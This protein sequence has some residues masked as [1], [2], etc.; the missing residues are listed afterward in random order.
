MKIIIFLST[1]IALFAC[2]PQPQ[3][4]QEA[5]P[6]QEGYE[7]K[8]HVAKMAGKD[9][10]LAFYQNDDNRVGVCDTV[11]LDS[12]GY[13]VF[14]RPDRRLGRGL[15]LI[16]FPSGN[17]IQLLI[18]SQQY[19]T[20]TSDTTD[21]INTLV[22]ENSPENTEFIEYQKFLQT[23]EKKMQEIEE[24]FSKETEPDEAVREKY[25]KR[26]DAIDE[27]VRARVAGIRKQYPGTVL[28]NFLNF[29]LSPKIPDYS[30][31]V[32][33]DAP[34]REN[35]IRRLSLYYLKKHYWDY[36]DLTDTMFFRIKEFKPKLDRYFTTL[37]IPNPDTLYEACVS[38]IEKARPNKTMFRYLTE[39][40]IMHAFNHEIMGMD[41]AFVR[42]GERYY[43]SGEA[44]WRTA[45]SQKQLTD[46]IYK[47]QYNL[48]GN[49]ALDLKLPSLEGGVVSLLETQ[50]PYTLLLF[51]EPNCGHCKTVVPDVK[52]EIF[53][54]FGPHGLKVFAVM[55]LTEKKEWEAFVE[56]N[57][58]FDFINCYDPN[59][60]SNYWTIYNVFSTPVLYLLDK[61]KKIIAKQLSVEQLVGLLREEYKRKGI[62][63]R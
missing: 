19:F 63:V 31:T 23:Q 4:Q 32:A 43:L 55:T 7:I 27:E 35:E 40:C 61:D 18:G 46:E 12:A 41:K 38:I 5:V 26:Q 22:F 58:L 29:T 34:D 39:Y 53:D 13:G 54:R 2:K 9:A 49:T 33:A 3:Q 60:Q 56:K 59:R 15:Y 62:E 28:A 47:R 16:Y 48:L 45:E 24:E 37:I 50:A 25:A 1:C 51:W 17:M 10:M 36:T 21:Y 52:K 14:R 20:V 30:K 42:L 44:D 6:P 57:Q 8:L 11:H